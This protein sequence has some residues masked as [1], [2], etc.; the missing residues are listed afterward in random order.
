MCSELAPLLCAS[1]DDDD[2]LMMARAYGGPK[3]LALRQSG[4]R[5]WDK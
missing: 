3:L 2:M 5:K 1:A 4:R